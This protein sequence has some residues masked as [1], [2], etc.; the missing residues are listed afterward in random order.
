MCISHARFQRI[1]GLKFGS[2]T[3][4]IPVDG[5]FSYR[6]RLLKNGQKS[7][8]FAAHFEHHFNTT[9]SHTYL[10]KYMTFK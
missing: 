9:T 6:L 3:K 8:S 4:G 10:R 2:Q 1:V 7:D 5:Q